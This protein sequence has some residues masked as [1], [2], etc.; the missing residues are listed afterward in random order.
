[1]LPTCTSEQPADSWADTRQLHLPSALLSAKQQPAISAW[2]A[3]LCCVYTHV[4]TTLGQG[5][6]YMSTYDGGRWWSHRPAAA[7]QHQPCHRSLCTISHTSRPRAL[8]RASS[9]N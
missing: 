2:A 5:T 7:S 1:M 6:A 8:H 9:P 4:E 3:A